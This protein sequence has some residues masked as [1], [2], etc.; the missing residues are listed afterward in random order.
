MAT[1]IIIDHLKVG[2]G[3]SFPANRRRARCWENPEVDQQKADI[4]AR[5]LDAGE[6]GEVDPKRCDSRL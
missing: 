5:M 4:A 3:S 6:S 2:S 1:V